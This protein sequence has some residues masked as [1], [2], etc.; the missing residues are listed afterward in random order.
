MI[1]G[2][3]LGEIASL[4]CSGVWSVTDGVRAVLALNSAFRPFEGRGGMVA[5]IASEVD[6]MMLLEQIGDD[7]LVLACVNA[8]RQT[9]VSG[10]DAALAELER[11][12]S[13]SRCKDL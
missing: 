9:V 3:S 4:V 10:P 1:I 6:A 13:P 7:G 5:M 12:C 8:P 11:T 2:Q